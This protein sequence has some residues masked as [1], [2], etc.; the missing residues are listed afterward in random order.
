ME[1]NVYKQEDYFYYKANDLDTIRSKIVITAY[2]QFANISIYI[3]D[4]LI[5]KMNLINYDDE[6]ML[7]KFAEFAV[8]SLN[9]YC[10]EKEVHT[11]KRLYEEEFERLRS[12]LLNECRIT[13]HAVYDAMKQDL[14]F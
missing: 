4:I 12:H 6:V 9:D 10:S 11:C 5:S 3:D 13:D 14:L 8:N 2:G 7:T 1:L